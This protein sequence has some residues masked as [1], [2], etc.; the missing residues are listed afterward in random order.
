[1]LHEV[2]LVDPEE[3]V[4]AFF[5]QEA[6]DQ[7]GTKNIVLARRLGMD[8]GTVSN[9]K[10]GKTPIAPSRWIAIKVALGLAADWLPP[11]LS[12]TPKPNPQ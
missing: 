3:A 2:P 1:M 5:L 9:W 11:S 4:P 12:S 10:T 8:A 6:L 7:T